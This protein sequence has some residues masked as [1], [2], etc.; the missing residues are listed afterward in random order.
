M[1]TVAAAFT[2]ILLSGAA[3][4]RLSAV[5]GLHLMSRH[6]PQSDWHGSVIPLHNAARY[7]DE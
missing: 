2:H 7:L 5:N 1:K 6:Q 4:E 3:R